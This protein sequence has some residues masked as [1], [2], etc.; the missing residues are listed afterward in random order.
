[1]FNFHCIV[2]YDGTNFNGW[3]KQPGLRTVQDEIETALGKVF[4]DRP[5][6]ICAGRTDKGVHA[7]GQSISF[8]ITK[9]NSKIWE[10]QLKN[11]ANKLTLRLNALLPQDIAI[12]S[13]QTVKNSFDARKSAKS[14]TY[15]YII[16][17][18]P[19]RSPLN[20]NSSW[21]ISNPIDIN[22]INEIAKFLQTKRDYSVFDSYNSIFDYKIVN[23][24]CV[25]ALKRGKFIKISITGDRFLYKMIRKI[26]G[27][28]VRI[29]KN[30]KNPETF[31]QAVLT[32]N[33]AAIGKPAPACGL[34]LTKVKY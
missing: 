28:M 14:K 21:H 6:I 13:I 25:K 19:Q 17:N 23:L 30:E 9:E 11:D 18:S 2:E 34:Y 22:K 1:M 32:K 7:C 27:E 12:K 29:G 24:Q 10:Q 33:K 15:E 5:N 16:Y 26:A 4:N 3:G 8:K 20:K 31:K